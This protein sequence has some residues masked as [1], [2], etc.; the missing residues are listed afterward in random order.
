MRYETVQ[1]ELI[2]ALPEL[3]APRDRLVADWLTFDV[4]PPDESTVFAGT[5][6]PLLEIVLALDPATPGRDAVLERILGFRDAMVASGD[7]RLAGL[8]AEAVSETLARHEA[9]E[10]EEEPADLWGVRAELADR[11]PRTPL[12][13]IPGISHPADHLGLESLDAARDAPDGTVLLSTFGTTR[14]YVVVRADEV[15]LDS[16]RLHRAARDL[17]EYLGDDPE[18]EP[19][20][21]LRRIPLGERVWN[22]DDGESRHG[23]LRAEPWIAPSLRSLRHAILDHLAARTERLDLPG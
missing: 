8:A 18:G 7:P 5:L 15:A 20:M 22:M 12:Q 23:R 21:R 17:A 1:R 10:G 2:A 19:A 11:L 13:A 16:A 4:T 6:T 14:L 3:R 9:G